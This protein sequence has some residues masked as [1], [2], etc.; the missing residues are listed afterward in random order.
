[1]TQGGAKVLDLVTLPEDKKQGTDESSCEFSSQKRE[2]EIF[3]STLTYL[4]LLVI[5]KT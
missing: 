2:A 5:C 3:F 4:N 1:M